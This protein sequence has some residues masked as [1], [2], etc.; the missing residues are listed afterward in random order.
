MLYAATNEICVS[1]TVTVA[2]IT[3]TVSQCTPQEA[4]GWLYVGAIVSFACAGLVLL[5]LF[6]IRE[7]I[8][9]TAM[10]LKSVSTV[11]IQL[12]ELILI[13]FGAS[14]LSVGYAV[15]MFLSLHRPLRSIFSSPF[16]ALSAHTISLL[17]LL[18]L[19][20]SSGSSRTWR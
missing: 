17:L 15:R 9:F 4:Q 8:A 3:Q 1:H 7:R 12:P 14:L 13:Q 11:L 6:C 20:R 16:T 2:G 19:V 18:P 5:W 10:I